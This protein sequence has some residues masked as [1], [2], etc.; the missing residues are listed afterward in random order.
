VARNFLGRNDDV[1]EV[2]QVALR[3]LADLGATLVDVEVPNVDKYDASELEVLLTELKAG[4]ASYF[5]AFAPGAEVQSLDDLVRYNE[6]HRARVMPFFGQEHFVAAL[7]KGGLDDPGYLAAF[8][9]GRRYAREEGID[10]V[11]EEHSLDALVAPTG[12]PAWVTDLVNGDHYTGS[13]S[14]PA[15]VA[16]Y[17]H[18][19][20]PAGFVRGLPVGL[21][22]VGPAWSEPRLIAFAYAFEQATTHRSAPRFASTIDARA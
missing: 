20:V 22:F 5:A 17:P 18:V 7:A 13:F 11:L 3:A 9:N 10:Q 16:G 14:S 2:A 15:A 12:G 6:R 8:A 19:T 4:L 21:S 1:R